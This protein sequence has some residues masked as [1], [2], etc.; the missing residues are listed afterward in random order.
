M[1]A[2]ENNS[3]K[4]RR[5]QWLVCWNNISINVRNLRKMTFMQFKKTPTF[6]EFVSAVSRNECILRELFFAIHSKSVYFNLTLINDTKVIFFVEHYSF[7]L[8]SHICLIVHTLRRPYSK[9]LLGATI[10]PNLVP[11]IL[12]NMF[13]LEMVRRCALKICHHIPNM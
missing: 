11:W 8:K 3:Y 10:E 7:A 13:S 5:L 1:A 2:S 6:W 4:M 9:P 12:Q